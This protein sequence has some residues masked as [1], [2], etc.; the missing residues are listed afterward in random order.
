MRR[1]ILDTITTS[2]LKEFT[3]SKGFN[4]LVLSDQF[5]MFTNFC[6]I[7]KEYD[8]VSFDVK[9][10]STGKNTQGI[11]GIGIIV[12]NKLCH[13]PKE[14]QEL[15]NLN[16]VLNV[17]FILIQSKTSS[18]FDGSQI[19]NLFRWSKSFFSDEPNLFTTNEMKNFIE[20]KDFIYSNSK[21]MKERSP[22][23]NLY[24]CSTGKWNED[25]N[26]VQVVNSN[27]KELDDLNLFED[28]NF[29]PCGTKNLQSLYRKTKEPVEASIKFE[30]KVTIP[31]IDNVKV[32]YS[33]ML[34]FSEFQKLIIDETGKMKS[35]FNDNIRDYLE[36]E[37]NPVNTDIAKTLKGGDLDSFCIL[38]NGITVVADEI[39]GAGDD[40]TITN[41][42]IVNGCQTSNVLFENK[43]VKEIDNMHIPLKI[44]VTNNTDIKSQIT[45]ATNNQTAVD[46]VEL[47]ALTEFQRNLEYY[48]NALP[49]DEH[50]LHY[51]RRTNQYKNSEVPMNRIINRETQIKVFSS[52]FL[53]KPHLVAG[54]YGKLIKDM[55]EDIFHTTHDYLPYYTCALAYYKLEQCYNQNI[56]NKSSWRF[57]HQLLL[58][59][60]FI[61]FPKTV[62]CFKDKKNIDLFCNEII[63]ILKNNELCIEK[64]KEAVEF[65]K[66]D[67]LSLNF[68]DRKTVER[69]NTTDTILQELKNKY[70]IKQ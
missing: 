54:Y 33:G 3:E 26:L 50:K 64:F 47:E 53:N 8:S 57:R 36:Q 4:S 44:I 17:T 30:K 2:F 11:D 27:K 60:R 43:N 9:E 12:N 35:V 45:R 61:V 42:Q 66:S 21:Y 6:I 25:K 56:L 16:R 29:Y 23:C 38:N 63:I 62:P 39:S 40:I 59:F 7:N 65:L 51:E 14:I 67:E 55:G 18:K 19:D 58:I 34:P 41:Y 31:S 5:E 37:N 32:A 22:N 68:N 70:L 52:M 48:Y 13:S 69:K 1:Y 46:A 49:N 20:M 28:I 24:F 10:I 15:V